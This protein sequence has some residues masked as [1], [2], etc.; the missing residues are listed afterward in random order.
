[1]TTN[2]LVHT[3][4]SIAGLR[5]WP[6]EEKKLLLLGYKVLSLSQ[7][8]MLP[9]IAYAAIDYDETIQ[10]HLQIMTEL[11]KDAFVLHYFGSNL[12]GYYFGYMIKGH[13]D[14]ITLKLSCLFSQMPEPPLSPHQGSLPSG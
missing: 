7:G 1:M 12:K 10:G 3:W 9:S 6:R 8:H 13:S 2:V 4:A 14:L 11:S 5:K